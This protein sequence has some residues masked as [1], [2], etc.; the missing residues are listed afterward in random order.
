ML[1]KN[2]LNLFLL[3]FVVV[4]AYL[5]INSESENN[6]LDRLS[7]INPA[8]I[9]T[10]SIRHQTYQSHLE[11]QEK[12]HD[13]YWQF[14]QPINID[15]NSFRISSL[16]KLLNAPVHA[17]YSLA[18]ISLEQSGL[19]N[20]TTLIQFDSH[21]IQFGGIN[22]LNGLRFILYKSKI[23][24]IEDVYSPLIR[25]NFTTLAALELLPRNSKINKLV[26]L[27]QTIKKDNQGRWQSEPPLNAD[28]I[29]ESIQSWQQ[30]QAFAVHEYLK[31]DSLG[32]V[33]IFLENK[34]YPITFQITDTEPWL[35]IARPD[36]KIEYH[37]DLDVYN[38]LINPLDPNAE[39]LP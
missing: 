12:I 24:L 14:T 16:L 17:K 23:Y 33:Q 20:P 9:K 30:H 37:L 6:F 38:K 36:L 15:A 1:K 34:P 8:S 4:L 25:S 21:L 13:Q 22:P 11:K 39:T 35:I 3:V 2:L 28:T 19:N 10:I 32:Q 26:L 7:D 29:I 18:E 27:N 31:R 5:V